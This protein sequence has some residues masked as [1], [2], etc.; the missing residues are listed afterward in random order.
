MCTEAEKSGELCCKSAGRMVNILSNQLKR[1]FLVPD[2]GN[3]LTMLQRHMLH[4]II[5]GSMHQDIFQKD[6]EAEFQIRKSTATGILQLLEKKGFIC[7]ESVE[8]DGRLKRVVPTEKA[9]AMRER[10]I[11]SLRCA[12]TQMLQG[13]SREDLD[14]CMQVLAQMSRNLS[15]KEQDCKEQECRLT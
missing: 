13:I 15:C 14:T 6:V 4:F 3:E 1:R 12:E 10:V 8:R 11:Q 7:R 9:L 2:D 5:V